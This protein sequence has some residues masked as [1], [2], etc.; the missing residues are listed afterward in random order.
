MYMYI[1]YYGWISMQRYWSSL[2]YCPRECFCWL[3][4]FVK[5]QLYCL[6]YRS[7]PPTP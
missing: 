5:I 2:R 6:I 1:Y 4:I 7:P 3:P